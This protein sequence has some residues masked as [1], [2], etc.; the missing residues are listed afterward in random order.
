[1]R[2]ILYAVVCS[3]LCI[4]LAACSSSSKEEAKDSEKEEVYKINDVV[5]LKNSKLMVTSVTAHDG[6]QYMKPKEGKK[7]VTV[8]ISIDNTS[9]KEINYNPLNFSIQNSLGQIESMTLY[10]DDQALSS[11]KLAPGGHVEGSVTFEEPQEEA[12]GQNMVLI[13]KANAFD[14]DAAATIQLK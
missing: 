9:E 12:V 10:Q 14:S 6:I 11:G 8:M 13:I 3:F 2:K 7:Y 4:C 5:Q 1:M